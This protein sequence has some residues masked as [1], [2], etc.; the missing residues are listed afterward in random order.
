MKKETQEKKAKALD[1]FF[2]AYGSIRI[3]EITPLEAEALDLL[4]QVQEENS[5]AGKE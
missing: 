4:L 5:R 1:A 2:K 3:A